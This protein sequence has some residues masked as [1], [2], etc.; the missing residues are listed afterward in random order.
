V[1]AQKHVAKEISRICALPESERKAEIERIG[2]EDGAV[3]V[4]PAE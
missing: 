2:R 4:C 1:S 3:I